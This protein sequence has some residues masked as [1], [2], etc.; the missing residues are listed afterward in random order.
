MLVLRSREVKVM[1]YGEGGVQGNCV[2]LVPDTV[3]CFGEGTFL[4]IKVNIHNASFCAGILVEAYIKT[5]N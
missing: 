2:D 5:A 4:G 1:I 3:W